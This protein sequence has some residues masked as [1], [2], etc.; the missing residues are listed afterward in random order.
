MDIPLTDSVS[1][2]AREI[3]GAYGPVFSDAILLSQAMVQE[4]STRTMGAD[5]ED[6]L[7][8]LFVILPSG[9]RVKTGDKLVWV[10][11]TFEV[12]TVER[13]S[14]GLPAA[15]QHVELLCKRL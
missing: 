14:S 8:D 9:T 3:E 10:S 12:L 4:V 15:A 5:G 6:V 7:S 1:L 11:R 2:I 13:F